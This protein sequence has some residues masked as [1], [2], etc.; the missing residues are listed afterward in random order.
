MTVINPLAREISAKVVCSRPG[1]SGKTT[2]LEHDRSAVNEIR[3]APSFSH[4]LF[5]GAL[6][7]LALNDHVLK[8]MGALPA[9][10]GKLSDVA[11]L[12]VAPLVLAWI[13]RVRS[14]RA[15]ALAHLATGAGFALIQ[16]P[17]IAAALEAVLPVRIWADPSDLLALPALLVS[18]RLLGREE[19]RPR[20]AIGVLALA[21]CTA[22]T[23]P[24]QGDPPPRY[25][26]PPAGILETD[27]FIRNHL[28]A[29]LHIGVRRIEDT[30]T[31]DCD[32]LL[33]TPETMLENDD[34]TDEREWTVA[35]RDG[36]PLWD[37]RD[38]AMT[39]DCYAVILRAR[40]SRWLITWRHG[41]PPL[42]RIQIR[43][44]PHEAIE[45]GAM[46]ISNDPETPPNVAANVTVRVWEE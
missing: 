16:V 30:V 6:A 35:A 43:L 29:D 41:T 18:Y 7:T 5:L 4:P 22:T 25:P 13:C 12:L 31:V 26:F 39:R 44:E 20:R 23:G 46:R 38:G 19:G 11:G 2:T 34:F 32:G 14:R 17:A 36:V 8:A 42:R 27:L 1:L 45:A 40:D 15:F 3:P 21:F 28:S 10:S 9:L 33:Q 37:R 24:G